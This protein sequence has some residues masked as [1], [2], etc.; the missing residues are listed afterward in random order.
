[1][2]RAAE[3]TPVERRRPVRSRRWCIPSAI[4]RS[5]GEALDG[6]PILHEFD[7]EL[8]LLLW[9]V[10]RDVTLWA[11]TPESERRRL[12]GRCST[13]RP[14]ALGPGVPDDLRA[15]LLN[16]S[17]LL[18]LPQGD[19]DAELLALA[20]L[21]VMAWA[22]RRK[23]SGTALAFAQAGALA[24]PGF[25]EAALQTAVCARE[26]GETARAETWGRRALAVAR[27]ERNAA[28]HATANVLLGEL[29][30]EAGQNA[31]ARH[32]LLLGLRMS[33]RTLSPLARRDAAYGLFRLALESGDTAAAGRMARIAERHCGREHAGSAKVLLE[34]ARFWT[35]QGQP[36]RVQA[37]LRRLTFHLGE[38]THTGALAVAALSARLKAETGHPRRSAVA[39]QRAW[40]LL[41]HEA[42]P[43]QAAYAAALDLAHAAVARR[44][45][46]ALR[47]AGDAALRFAPRVRYDW[48]RDALA[49]LASGMERG[50]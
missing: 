8:G 46:G 43:D 44:D 26:A 37:A 2:G 50:Q 15:S 31:R 7:G 9:Y 38:V 27:R 32:A 48:T 3:C 18:A 12:F 4:L 14:A 42:T 35:D 1:M 47:R 11:S 30:R 45:G 21:E 28:A 16:L 10:M 24:A 13:V 33:R 34:L 40:G 19:S 20:C 49:A 5:P 25:S 41:A 36:D 22:R 39:E 29:Y 17:A 23:A 6:V